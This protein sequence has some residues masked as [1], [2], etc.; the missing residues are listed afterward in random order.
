MKK[1]LAMLLVLL[2]LVSMAACNGGDSTDGTQNNGTAGTNGDAQPEGY[3]YT[4]ANVKLVP[5]ADFKPSELPEA[6]SVYQV[7]SCAIEGTDNVY[8]Y[9]TVEITA[10]DDGTGEIIYS[11]YI[12]DPNT[13]TDEGLYLGDALE[14]VNSLYGTDRTENGNEL[15][16]KKGKTMLV[17]IMENDTVSSIEYRAIM[18]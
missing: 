16:Y 3:S 13:P 11:I 18:E 4:L 9:T 1:I 10:F 2:L 12:I 8:N 5:G 15:V 7:P 14:Q 17:L 6:D